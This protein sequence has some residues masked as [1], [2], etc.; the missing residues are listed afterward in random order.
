MPAPSIIISSSEVSKVEEWLLLSRAV[1]LGL[2]RVLHLSLVFVSG[3]S[4]QAGLL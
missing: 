1:N 3:Q 2:S 4:G